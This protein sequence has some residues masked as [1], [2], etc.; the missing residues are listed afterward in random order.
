MEV[1]NFFLSIILSPEVVCKVKQQFLSAHPPPPEL[2]LMKFRD[3]KYKDA[4]RQQ[5]E[6]V[7]PPPLSELWIEN[8]CKVGVNL[9]I[10]L[11]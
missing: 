2:P 10:Y 7:I 5:A 4:L 6:N 8:I 1:R 11:L 3:E 9:F